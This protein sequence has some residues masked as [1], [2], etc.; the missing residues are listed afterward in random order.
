M[1][2]VKCRNE[3]RD[4]LSFCRMFLDR[5]ARC[6]G[7]Y[8]AAILMAVSGAMVLGLPKEGSGEVGQP[9]DCLHNCVHVTTQVIVPTAPDPNIGVAQHDDAIC[10]VATLDNSGQSNQRCCDVTDINVAFVFPDGSGAAYTLPNQTLAADEVIQCPGPFPQCAQQAPDAPC[11]AGFLYEPGALFMHGDERGDQVGVPQC[12]PITDQAEDFGFLYGWT[13]GGG[14]AQQPNPGAAGM[15]KCLSVDVPHHACCDPCKG[16]CV[17]IQKEDACDFP[18]I[19]HANQACEQVNCQPL[20]CEGNPGLPNDGKCFRCDQAVG[21]CVRDDPNCCAKDD[22]CQGTK[23]RLGACV[24]NKCG[25]GDKRPGLC[26]TDDQCAD[27]K[28]RSGVCNTDGSWPWA[29]NTCGLGD[30]E[31]HPD[32]AICC[33]DDSQC[34]AVSKCIPGGC[35]PV[36][37]RCGS[38]VKTPPECCES[39][40]QCVDRGWGTK[41]RSGLC[42]LDGTVP[43]VGD[44]RCYTGDKRPGCCESNDQ[45]TGKCDVCDL[46]PSS[47]THNTCVKGV[48]NCCDSD[49]QCSD[50]FDTKCREAVCENN[51]C[52]LGPKQ[53]KDCCEGDEWCKNWDTKCRTGVCDMGTNTCYLGEKTPPECCEDDFQCPGKCDVCSN[54]RC[55]KGILGC[56]DSDEQCGKCEACNFS[57]NTCE[58]VLNSDGSICCASDEQCWEYGTKCREGFCNTMKNKCDLRPPVPA[59]CCETDKN[60]GKCETCDPFTNRCNKD[61]PG[62]CTTDTQCAGDKCHAGVCNEANNTCGLSPKFEGCCMSDSQCGD[63][64][65]KCRPGLCVNNACVTGPETPNKDCCEGDEW[66]RNFDT[67]CRTYTCNKDTNVCESGPKI[68]FDCCETDAQCPPDP[69]CFDSFCN[70]ATNRCQVSGKFPNCCTSDDQCG[71]EW[72][73][74][75]D[76]CDLVTNTCVFS[77]VDRNCDDGF[78]CTNPDRCD[79]GNASADPYSGCVITPDDSKCKAIDQ[80]TVGICDPKNSR[81]P[82][83]TAGGGTGCTIVPGPP[84]NSCESDGNPCT[85]ERCNDFGICQMFR[86][87]PPGFPIG[88]CPPEAAYYVAV[89]GEPT[90]RGELDDK[91]LPPCGP[92]SIDKDGDVWLEVYVTE[93][94]FKWAT[95]IACATVD[96]N[97]SYEQPYGFPIN[98]VGDI[99]YGP[100]FTELTMVQSGNSDGQGNIKNL[101]GCTRVP[102]D[103]PPPAKIGVFP[104][105][106]LLARVRF[107][108]KQAC[109]ELKFMLASSGWSTTVHNVHGD[110]VASP[111]DYGADCEA[112]CRAHMYDLDNDCFVTALDWALFAGC[113]KLCPEDSAYATGINGESCNAANYVGFCKEAAPGCC[114]PDNCVGQ[115]DFPAIWGAMETTM[116][117]HNENCGNPFLKLPF[118]CIDGTSAAQ[119]PT[120]EE[121]LRAGLEP[122]SADWKGYDRGILREIDARKEIK[123]ARKGAG[124]R[125]SK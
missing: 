63:W 73:C 20:V 79:P 67:K 48:P 75:D 34:P 106:A 71:D 54:N 107:E 85:V 117:T 46:D 15:I 22:E 84:G 35:D 39:H 13:F 104:K 69:K 42:N 29:I 121:L 72:K 49:D 90:G 93:M 32:G 6:T 61:I 97:Y 118:P 124:T 119:L 99:E 37:N 27:D 47:P 28:C 115:E 17:D 5:R 40:Q 95:G 109:G 120:N 81:D 89:V 44:N 98:Q 114:S 8:R 125:G 55:V 94:A 50:D 56:C 33:T 59:D 108:P 112:A 111:V 70:T 58:K 30:K 92:R 91:E 12:P 66:C 10:F 52:V 21:E 4:K 23:C 14:V 43:G 101:G 25:L 24:D 78:S 3:K 18:Q 41:C 96:V 105:W 36:T 103:P 68:P 116:Q 2:D 113:W 86:P 83:A 1:R 57:T 7:R 60:C 11:P 80:C 38:G 88:V 74:T 53:P 51:K 16:T 31:L 110:P 62:C 26:C 100:A 76:W 65:T 45:C 87:T 9:K 19:L 123:G 102:H 122:P 82:G 77:R 64:E